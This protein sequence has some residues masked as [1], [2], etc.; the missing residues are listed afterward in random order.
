MLMLAF[1]TNWYSLR[2]FLF[3]LWTLKALPRSHGAKDVEA[4]L[5]HLATEGLTVLG[6]DRPP[7]TGAKIR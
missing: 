2:L 5:F 3:K 6:F 4:F 7:K 1:V